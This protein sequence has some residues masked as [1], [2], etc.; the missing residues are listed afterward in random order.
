MGRKAGKAIK[1]LILVKKYLFSAVASLNKIKNQPVLQQ[2]LL[3][4][5]DVTRAEVPLHDTHAAGL[6]VRGQGALVV[7]AEAVGA[8]VAISRHRSSPV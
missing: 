1:I 4:D 7:V 2:F 5:G 6:E 3:V 8:L